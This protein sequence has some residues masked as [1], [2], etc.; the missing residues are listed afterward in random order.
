LA[1]RKILTF[2]WLL[3]WAFFI[4]WYLSDHLWYQEVDLFIVSMFDWCIKIV[5]WNV[6]IAHHYDK[7]VSCNYA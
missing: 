3:L 1:M 5:K 6:M 4:R 7:K 2:S